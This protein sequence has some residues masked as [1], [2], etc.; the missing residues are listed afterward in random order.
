VTT[1]IAPHYL[2]NADGL[3]FYPVQVDTWA[4]SPDTANVTAKAADGWIDATRT[5]GDGGP[6]HS[7]QRSVWYLTSEPVTA[8]AFPQSPIRKAVQYR[9]KDET[10]ASARFPLVLTPEEYEARRQAEDPDDDDAGLTP[11]M[12]QPVY[13]EF[14]R[15]P[16][17]VDVSAMTP[18]PGTADENT[19]WGWEVERTAGLLYG[20][21]YHH[22]LP[23]TLHG[24]Q[25]V[26][27]RALEAR[28]GKY[29]YFAGKTGFNIDSHG[30][31]G[32]RMLLDFDVPV[33]RTSP[34]YGAGGRK[35]RGTQQVREYV[36]LN[37]EWNQGTKI[38]ANTKAEAVAIYRKVEADLFAWIDSHNLTV[39]SHCKGNG[40]TKTNGPKSS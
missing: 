1:H 5:E 24:V 34:R 20:Q 28:Y 29:E 3:C 14:A 25:A 27:T 16:Y 31:F 26:L 40:Y 21:W 23:G 6:G 9:L 10:A 39:C 32:V 36:P 13:E 37:I 12:Y 38:S 18:M 4:N 19:S 35:L 11:I 2:V 8:F 7:Y 33:F 30:K 17:Q 15:D 22:L